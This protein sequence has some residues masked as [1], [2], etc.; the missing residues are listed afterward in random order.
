MNYSYK[1]QAAI[2]YARCCNTSDHVL[3]PKRK[4][5]APFGHAWQSDPEHQELVIHIKA[6]VKWHT[7]RDALRTDEIIVCLNSRRQRMDQGGRRWELPTAVN[8]K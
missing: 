4:L 8:K 5:N 7:E 3:Y 6:S 2:E 1:D